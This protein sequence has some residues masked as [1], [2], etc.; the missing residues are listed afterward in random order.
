MNFNLYGW[1]DTS[2]LCDRN[3]YGTLIYAAAWVGIL[4]LA[5]LNGNIK[6]LKRAAIFWT[7]T[8]VIY[9]ILKYTTDIFNALPFLIKLIFLP[10]GLLYLP[11]YGLSVIIN[12]DTIGS[13]IILTFSLCMTISS[14]LLFLLK[15]RVK[16]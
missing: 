8:T 7:V 11:F 14:A 5:T 12:N 10:I 15:G 3:L 13:N 1:P 2:Y 4:I 16:G 9:V 6:I